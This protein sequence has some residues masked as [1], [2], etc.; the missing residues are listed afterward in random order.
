M[1]GFAPTPTAKA[2]LRGF[3]RKQA[4]NPHEPQPTTTSAEPP[5]DLTGAALDFWRR[6][7][8]ELVRIG[9]LTSIDRGEFALGCR[10][11]A[12]GEAKLTLAEQGGPLTDAALKALRES[13]RIFARFGIG[14]S[15]RTRIHVA[16]PQ[17]E[18]KWAK[19]VS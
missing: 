3:P 12:W 18:S 6:H 5:P 9:C 10:F 19:L 4:Q 14:A 2:R 13:S 11:R 15:D 17:P 16:P 1:P 8:P 7:V